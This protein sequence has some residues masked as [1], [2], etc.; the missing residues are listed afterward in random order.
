MLSKSDRLLVR[1]AARGV[2]GPDVAN[3]ETAVTARLQ[4]GAE[5]GKVEVHTGYVAARVG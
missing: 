2:K 1:E 3:F 4:L 5:I